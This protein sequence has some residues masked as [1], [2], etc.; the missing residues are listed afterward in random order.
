MPPNCRNPGHFSYM[1][2]G[3]HPQS[4]QLE[5]NEV[6][7]PQWGRWQPERADGGG[8]GGWMGCL[9]DTPKNQRF[10]PAPAKRE[11]RRTGNYPRSTDTSAAFSRYAFSS[12]LSF[13]RMEVLNRKIQMRRDFMIFYLENHR[14][15][16]AVR[17]CLN[18]IRADSR[19]SLLY[20]MF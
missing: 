1:L 18:R 11:P 19:C 9:S 5:W 17:R 7:P 16:N 13:V 2:I 6:L 12:K 10:L 4:S 14:I 8:A 20:T 3:F 15:D